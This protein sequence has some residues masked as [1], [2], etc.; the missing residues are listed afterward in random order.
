MALAFFGICPQVCFF[1]GGGEDIVASLDTA[2][3]PQG[4]EDLLIA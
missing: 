3:V 1:S 4:D 2:F